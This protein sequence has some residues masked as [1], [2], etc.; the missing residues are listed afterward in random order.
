MQKKHFVWKDSKGN[1]IFVYE[2]LPDKQ[3]PIKAVV[4]ISHGMAETAARYERLALYL[5]QHGYAVYANDHLGHGKTAGSPDQVGKLTQDCFHCLVSHMGG[6]TSHLR[7]KYGMKLPLFIFGHSMGSFLTQHYMVS[8]LNVNPEHVQGFILSGSNGPQ[9]AMLNGGIAVANLECALLGDH[10]R[11]T[12]I[13]AL[14]F[15]PYNKKFA[16]NR[17][18]ADWLSRDEQEVDKYEADPYCGLI[19][20]SGFFRDF[21]RGL[22]EIHR[23]DHVSRLRKGLKI[24]VLSGEDDPVGDQGKGVKKLV[25]MYENLGQQQVHYKLYPGGRHEILNEINRDEVMQDILTWLDG[26]VQR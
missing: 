23:Y 8:Y 3:I 12:L 21:F 24:F 26:Q 2:W 22:K 17:T 5:T 6:I 25:R 15:G 4:Q 14:V 7:I 9:G 13:T 19:F 16:P 20:T 10:H 1:A 18:G 11:S